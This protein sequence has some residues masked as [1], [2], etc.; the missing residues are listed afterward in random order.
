ME[1][2]FHSVLA[3]GVD[4]LRSHVGEKTV[5][6]HHGDSLTVVGQAARSLDGDQSLA[7]SSRTF[8]KVLGFDRSASS[9]PNC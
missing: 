4:H 7:C 6:T 5:E 1:S 3:V 8:E 9:A 2:S